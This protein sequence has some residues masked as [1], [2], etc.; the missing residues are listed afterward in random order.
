MSP[1]LPLHLEHG[2]EPLCRGDHP[3]LRAGRDEAVQ[4]ALQAQSVADDHVGVRDSPGIG[5]H[6]LVG[7]G[8]AADVN[9]R[10]DLEPVP[11]HRADEVGENA[12]GGHRERPCLRAGGVRRC[13]EQRE[14]AGC[15]H[16]PPSAYRASPV[17]RAHLVT[18][19]I[20]TFSHSHVWSLR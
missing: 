8:V 9:D 11:G 18:L 12:D 2:V 20:S 5:G 14:N 19:A 3:D 1:V 4:P 13:P 7:V 15:G 16:V 6:R 10:D 17:V